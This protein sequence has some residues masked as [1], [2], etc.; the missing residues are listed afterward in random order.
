M[1]TPK[2]IKITKG[3]VKNVEIIR[4][5]PHIKSIQLPKSFKN[6]KKDFAIKII[7]KIIKIKLGN[8]F[9]ELSINAIAVITS[10]PPNILISMFFKLECPL[11]IIGLRSSAWIEHQVP[12]LG[13]AGSN[14]VGGMFKLLY[15]KPLKCASFFINEA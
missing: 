6:P 3:I 13:V 7:P 14:P 9:V 5:I 4:I 15:R 1:I 12:N 8:M 10:I 2:I 11:K